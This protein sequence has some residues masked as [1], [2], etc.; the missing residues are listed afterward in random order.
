MMKKSRSLVAA[1]TIAA[2]L[3][4]VTIEHAQADNVRRDL[5][6]SAARTAPGSGNT[7]DVS[8][9]RTLFALVDVTT[10]S[11]TVT[12]FKAYL[13]GSSDGGVTWG[14]L[15]CWHQSKRV[16]SGPTVTFL[17]TAGS[18]EGLIVNE[19]A[20][21]SVA[22]TFGAACDVTTDTVRLGWEIAGTTP[23]ETFSAK[24]VCK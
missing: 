16:A 23:S 11:G 12:T 1:T 2:L 5:A 7:I 15:Q 19:T 21:V 24:L 4:S 22:T 17:A 13:E 3:G 8:S 6:A 18:G 14:G 9:C 10:G 20:V